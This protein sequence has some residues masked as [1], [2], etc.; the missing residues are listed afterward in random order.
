MSIFDVPGF[1]AFSFLHDGECHV[2][3]RWVVAAGDGIRQLGRMSGSCSRQHVGHQLCAL[4]IRK[5][6]SGL[7]P[8]AGCGPIIS[9]QTLTKAPWACLDMAF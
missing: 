8:G 3:Q 1:K 7:Q 4:S 9:R 6:T 5:N 2:S